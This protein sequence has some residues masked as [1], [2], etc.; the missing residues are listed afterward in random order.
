MAEKSLEFRLINENFW[1]RHKDFLRLNP[2]CEVPVLIDDDIIV[3]DS[4]AISEYLEDCYS[5][6]KLLGDSPFE[7]A[8]IRRLISWFDVKFFNEVGKFI[9]YEK[10][11]RYLSNVG[12]PSSD[13][14]RA[15]KTNI[16]NHLRYIE[17]LTNEH[18]YLASENITLA[19][20]TAAAHFSILDYLGEVPWER[21]L[22][23]KEWYALVKS[24]PSFRA[25]LADRIKG[26]MPPKYYTD[27][28]F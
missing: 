27:F 28:D 3:A 14:I 19:D 13:S 25:L 15:A 26:F 20:L 8:N 10:V 7:S 18:K 17:F 2:A 12:E 9:L 6:N 23:A 5:N 11:I 21:F 16:I 4:Y 24:R 1:Q 22:Y